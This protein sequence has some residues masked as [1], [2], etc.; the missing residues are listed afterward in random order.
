MFSGDW[1]KEGGREKEREREREGRNGE[2]ETERNGEREWRERKS[3]ALPKQTIHVEECTINYCT[4]FLF[5]L[6]YLLQYEVELCFCLIH[7]VSLEQTK[8]SSTKKMVGVVHDDLVS[9]GVEKCSL[10]G[11]ERE[12]E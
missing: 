7:L 12:G 1:K 8:V 3:N 11:I 6:A 5:I 4:F 2:K 10:D 9:S